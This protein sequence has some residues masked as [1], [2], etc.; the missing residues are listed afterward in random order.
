MEMSKQISDYICMCVFIG[1]Y[2]SEY[3][4]VGVCIIVT[5]RSQI[6]TPMHKV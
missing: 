6:Q 1:I 4:Y 5:V 3:V 2:V